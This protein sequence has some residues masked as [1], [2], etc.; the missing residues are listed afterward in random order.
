MHSFFSCNLPPFLV[1][2]FLSHFPP[3]PLSSFCEFSFHVLSL[4]SS[5]PL[6]HWA[7]GWWVRAPAQGNKESRGHMHLPD[8]GLPDCLLCRLQASWDGCFLATLKDQPAC[9]S[10]VL[11]I[12][13]APEEKLRD[14]RNPDN[15]S[16]T[17]DF[18]SVSIR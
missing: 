10:S 14:E 15:N 6:G 8:P 1:S 2:F 7:V 13:M 16:S 4:Q 12:P 17:P 18:P 3:F 11:T 9:A 5:S